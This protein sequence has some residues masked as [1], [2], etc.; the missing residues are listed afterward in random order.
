M[1]TGRHV[2]RG[3]RSESKLERSSFRGKKVVGAS[4][5][6]QK[7]WEQDASATYAFPDE[8]N[9]PAAVGLWF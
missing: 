9:D 6:L 1:D 4:S 5:S 2:D 7:P 3:R 8:W